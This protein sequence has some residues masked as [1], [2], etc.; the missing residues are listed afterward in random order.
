MCSWHADHKHQHA[1]YSQRVANVFKGRPIAHNHLKMPDA[2]CAGHCSVTASACAAVLV[3]PRNASSQ[4]PTHVPAWAA[5][6]ADRVEAFIDGV[7]APFREAAVRSS[8]FC[9]IPKHLRDSLA[10]TPKA[11]LVVR[12]PSSVGLVS[13]AS[14]GGFRHGSCCG[15]LPS[16]RGWHNLQKCLLGEH[17]LILR[18]E[19]LCAGWR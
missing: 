19:F 10:C 4:V 2:A 6:I 12:E 15:M 11:Q 16:Q 5:P 18:G 13:I 8:A 14:P 9:V 3:V 1:Y 7:E 17:W